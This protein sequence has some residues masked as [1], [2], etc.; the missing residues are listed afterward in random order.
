MDRD[1]I[2]KSRKSTGM[3]DS[4]GN[5]RSRLDTRNRNHRDRPRNETEED[6][7]LRPV[8]RRESDKLLLQAAELETPENRVARL[9]G[10]K[11]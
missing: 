1:C 8:K 7:R 3:T 4:A 6:K 2:K 10:M 5:K 9:D 11:T